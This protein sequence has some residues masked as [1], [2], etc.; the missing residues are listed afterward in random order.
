MICLKWWCCSRTPNLRISK[1]L[2]NIWFPYTFPLSSRFLYLILAGFIQI[3]LPVHVIFLRW[4]WAY[5]FNRICNEP[6]EKN[7]MQQ[8]PRQ[9]GST[10]YHWKRWDK[11]HTR[12]CDYDRNFACISINGAKRRRRKPDPNHG[13]TTVFSNMILSLVNRSFYYSVLL[14]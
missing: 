4:L 3:Y 14:H 10:F 2:Y 6:A 1:K 8:M 13:F 11:Y 9:L 12:N 5:V 7:S